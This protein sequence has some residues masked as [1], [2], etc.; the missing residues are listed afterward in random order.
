MSDNPGRL[1]GAEGFKSFTSGRYEGCFDKLLY[2]L[3]TVYQIRQRVEWECEI[4]R[5]QIFSL[6]HYCC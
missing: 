2:D 4:K 3:V 6:R 5:V 1:S